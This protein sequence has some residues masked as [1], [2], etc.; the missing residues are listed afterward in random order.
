MSLDKVQ[1]RDWFNLLSIYFAWY[2]HQKCVEITKRVIDNKDDLINNN[3]LIAPGP[4]L[5]DKDKLEESKRVELSVE[6]LTW[7]CRYT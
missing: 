2:S 4:S 3:D 6:S 1:A 7:D 5:N